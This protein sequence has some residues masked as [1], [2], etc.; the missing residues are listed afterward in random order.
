MNEE[1]AE[2]ENSIYD[3]IKSAVQND[4]CEGDPKR[5]KKFGGKLSEEEIKNLTTDELL[6][7]IENEGKK[8]PLQDLDDGCPSSNGA[9]ENKSIS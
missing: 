2:E 6:S 1:F 4:A 8:I 5:K 3:Y 7:Y 9:E